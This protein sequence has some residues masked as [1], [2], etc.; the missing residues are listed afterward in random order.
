LKTNKGGV[1]LLKAL[2]L[3]PVLVSFAA[4]AYDIDLSGTVT[5][6]SGAVLKDVIVTLEGKDVRSITNSSGKYS[7]Q[8]VP[9]VRPLISPVSSD[10][11][12]LK[13][14]NMVFS[15]QSKMPV[16]IDV[17]DLRGRLVN[18]AV[19]RV[20][21]AGSHSVKLS[22]AG[23]VGSVFLIRVRMGDKVSLYKYM[24]LDH[25]VQRIS[26]QGGNAASSIAKLF[27]SVD[28]LRASKAGY[29]SAR[30]PISALTGVVDITL[31]SLKN[32]NV[33][34]NPFDDGSADR[35][36]Q[37]GVAQYFWG[38]LKTGNEEPLVRITH[39]V[40]ND[41][42]DLEV[43]FNPHFVDNTYGSEGHVGWN[44]KRPHTFKDL[45]HSDHVQIAVVNGDG[46]TVFHG[47]LDLLSQTSLVSSGYACLGPFGGDGVI[48]KGDPSMIISFGSS[49]DDNWNYYGY[50]DTVNS[51]VTDSTYKVNP[52][53]PFFQYYTIYRITF[54]P[55][56]FG[57]SGYGE[58][59]MTSVH[60]SPSKD[61]SGTITV[62]EKPGPTPG[63][64]QD[65]FRFLIPTGTVTPP[66]T[67]PD[68]IPPDIG[69]D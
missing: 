68:T 19:N 50:R 5:N 28:T 10:F 13:N 12:V 40:S 36:K 39:A 24:S 18:V 62:V 51:P 37:Y 57:P 44:P 63:S 49:L 42:F 22:N 17:F 56:I 41:A 32:N 27:A 69:V 14:G 7:I 46:D 34:T 3:V 55:E 52:Q 16:R 35:L 2:F 25:S 47:R 9:V 67:P 26:V 45:Y 30:I 43:T 20:L 58:V 11:S 53:Y 64:P 48:Y 65:P 61:G 38:T 54:N 59:H 31:D 60:A 29:K 6:K 66:E 4:A 1:M 21:P 8:V 33:G 15:V 23:T